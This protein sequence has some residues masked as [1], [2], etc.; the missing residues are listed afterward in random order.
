MAEGDELLPAQFP[1]G[2]LERDAGVIEPA[3][4]EEDLADGDEAVSMTRRLDRRASACQ[5]VLL[6]RSVTEL[7][8]FP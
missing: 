5:V 2:R 4:Q 7:N 8:E 6:N 3:E 1:T